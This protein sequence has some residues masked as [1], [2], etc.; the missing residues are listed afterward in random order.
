M[1]PRGQG[2]VDVSNRWTMMLGSIVVWLL[3]AMSCIDEVLSVTIDQ[4]DV[5]LEVGESVQLSATVAV[6]GYASSAVVWSS[7]D[8]TVANVDA[9]GLVLGVSEGSATVNATSVADESKHAHVAVIVEPILELELCGTIARN[10][11]LDIIDTPYV[12]CPGGASVTD[13]AVLRVEPGVTVVSDG[14]GL[15]IRSAYTDFAYRQFH[16]A[17]VIYAIG[18][19]DAPIRFEGARAEA[20]SWGGI[21]I[22]S[23]DERNHLSFVEVA[24][25]GAGDRYNLELTGQARVTITDS[26]F[27]DALGYGA[28]VGSATVDLSGFARN[29]FRGNTGAGMRIDLAHMPYLDVASTFA[30]NGVDAIEVRS[31]TTLSGPETYVWPRTLAPFWLT[32]GINVDT[33]LVVE[34]GFHSVAS[35][36]WVRVRSGGTIAAVGT[37]LEPISFTGYP[38][39]PGAWSGIRIES[40]SPEN[41]LRHVD[42]AHGGGASGHNNI[43]LSARLTLAD[44]IV[45]D[46]AACGI[47]VGRNAALTESNNTYFGNA[48]GDICP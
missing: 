44:S 27:R 8:P 21:R 34:P 6:R 47:H 20:G 48:S 7:D 35:G 25:G 41:Q 46:S 36:S 22:T 40:D 39:E 38:T 43:T 28:F 17:G 15:H 24:H 3:L 13:G 9:S 4:A 10:R 12:L 45:R 23:A 1:R 42:I 26:L 30:A 31:G 29:T 18:T 5:S 16:P 11:T 19:A 33:H 14:G 2:G 37:P 32:R